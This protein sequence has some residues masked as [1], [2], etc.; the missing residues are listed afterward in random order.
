FARYMEMALYEPALGYY[1]AGTAKL[2]AAGDFVTAAEIS[3]LFGSTLAGQVAEIISHSGGEVLELG[4]GSGALAVSMLEELQARNRL[5]ERYR[6]LEI[7]PELRQRQRR[8]LLQRLPALS[9]RLEWITSLPQRFRGV[10]VANEVL[11]AL[12]VHL[13]SWRGTDV[14]ERGVIC[15]GDAFAWEERR[16]APGALE[17]AAAQL[18]IE[19]PYRSEL[20]LAGP[21][22]VRT[23]AD[24]LERGALLWVD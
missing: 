24:I 13:L 9:E 21:A 8:M 3:P 15:K 23:F 19:A 4:A 16:L 2:G 12:P 10:V 6:I 11:D 22:L 17:D 7:S 20:S 1:V 14:Y 18:Q 5:P